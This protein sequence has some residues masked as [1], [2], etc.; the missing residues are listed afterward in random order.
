MFELIELIVELE[1]GGGGELLT[2]IMMTT[3]EWGALAVVSA[4]PAHSVASL[5]TIGSISRRI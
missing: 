1:E 4:G 2:L 5:F 3:R